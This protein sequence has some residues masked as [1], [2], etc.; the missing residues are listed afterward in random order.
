MD[1]SANPSRRLSATVEQVL[2]VASLFWVL[3]ANSLFFGAALTRASFGPNYARLV[4]LKKRY[5]PD[6]RFRF[7]QNIAPEA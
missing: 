1:V 4:A 2:A 5:D 3:S 7:N 6:N